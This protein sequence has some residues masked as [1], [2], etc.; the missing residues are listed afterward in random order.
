M[1]EDTIEF[2]L[3]DLVIEA[4]RK[5]VSEEAIKYALEAL[6]KGADGRRFCLVLSIN[7]SR[8]WAGETPLLPLHN[9]FNH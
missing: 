3:S 4:Y 8:V 6:R 7:G 1:P 5:G 9:E 2:A